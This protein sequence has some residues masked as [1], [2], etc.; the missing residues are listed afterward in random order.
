MDATLPF[1]FLVYLSTVWTAGKY[2]LM[3]KGHL[4]ADTYHELFIW[5]HTLESS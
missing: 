3:I 1:Y 4:W 5:I 2:F